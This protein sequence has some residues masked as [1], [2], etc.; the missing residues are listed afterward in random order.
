[1]FLL[2]LIKKLFALCLPFTAH[3]R[4][5]LERELAVS[6]QRCECTLNEWMS[7]IH[8]DLKVRKQGEKGQWIVHTKQNLDAYLFMNGMPNVGDINIRYTARCTIV[9]ISLSGERCF[10]KLTEYL[11]TS[12]MKMHVGMED[13]VLFAR[14]Q[15]ETVNGKQGDF[16]V[17]FY[18]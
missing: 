5:R 10:L 9:S 11:Y 16:I 3:K 6:L 17:D 2:R 18:K 14:L 1:M 13:E 7:S 12:R 4:I 15:L 8:T